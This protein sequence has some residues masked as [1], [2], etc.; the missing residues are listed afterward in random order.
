M[1]ILNTNQSSRSLTVCRSSSRLQTE[2]ELSSKPSPS[3][4]NEFVLKVVQ[5]TLY[6]FP[7]SLAIAYIRA[8]DGYLIAEDFSSILDG[9]LIRKGRILHVVNGMDHVLKPNL[10]V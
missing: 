6:T 5:S 7:P 1:Q 10:F 2:I 9:L 3:S 8:D 4:I